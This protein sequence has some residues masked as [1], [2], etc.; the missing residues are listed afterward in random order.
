MEN[1]GGA[2]VPDPVE[3][4]ESLLGLDLLL[5]AGGANGGGEGWV[6]ATTA[7]AAWNDNL[8]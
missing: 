6:E 3:Q 4:D 5:G 8:A 2:P 1:E 7:D